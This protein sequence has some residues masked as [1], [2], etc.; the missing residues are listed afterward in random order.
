MRQLP[1]LCVALAFIIF[2]TIS[3][4]TAFGDPPF[5]VNS[6]IA[7]RYAVAGRLGEAAT[8]VSGLGQVW[9]R[10]EFRFDVIHPSPDR[11]DWGLT[12]EM[13]G[14]LA[15]RGVRIL[16][17]LDYSVGWATP[18]WTGP[19]WALVRSMP[20][21]DAW[22]SFVRAV[23]SRYKGRVSA[24]E[25]WNEENHDIF[26][27]PQPDVASYVRLLKAS[28]A[29]I[30]AVDPT[31]LVVLGGTSGVDVAF[32]ESVA[33][34]GGWESFDVLAV[35]TYVGAKSPEAGRLASSELA[36]AQALLNRLGRKPV[37]ITEMGWP[38]SSG[39]W[40]VKS[41][42]TQASYL[43]RGM[44]AA[45]SSGAEKVFWY[46]LAN[47]GWDT[48]SDEA[49]YGLLRKDWR[50]P[51][52]GYQAYRTL[53]AVLSGAL[54]QG[55]LDVQTGSRVYLPLTE[56]PVAWHVWGDGAGGAASFAS[57]V[58]LSGAGSLRIDYWFDAP[59]KDYVD[60]SA[61]T[62]VP[63]QPNKVGLW[64]WGD[65]G[66]HLLWVTFTDATG[67]RFMVGLGNVDGPG[68]HLRTARLADYFVSSGGNGD[69]K[70]DYPVTFQ[71]LMVDNDPDGKVGRGTLYVDDLFFEEGPDIQAFRFSRD[72]QAVDVVWSTDG[73]ATVTLP[74]SS[75]S[76]TVTDRDGNLSS[77]AVHDG[78]L[79]IDVSD[80][81]KYVLHRPAQLPSHTGASVSSSFTLTPVK[82]G[83]RYFSETG[84]NVANGFLYYWQQNGGLER[85]GYPI[86]E[87]F[88]EDGLTVQYFERAK[89]E[90]HPE[91]RGTPY[92]VQLTLLGR[93]LTS[94]RVFEPV[95][96]FSSTFDRWYFP[97]TGHSLAYGFLRY[98]LQNGGLP[99]F[100]YPISEEF[101]ERNSEDGKV[102]T[103]Q[104]FERQRFEYHPEHRGTRFEVLLGLLGK[105]MA[106]ARGYLP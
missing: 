91:L 14:R 1:K 30:K 9:A 52:K 81:P 88:V 70:I 61:P 67:E 64:L 71:S 82:P 17:L 41:E 11:W 55:R 12:D 62:A 102:Y 35:H 27:H 54:P 47:D 69:G 3:P 26:W 4:A 32:L 7:T 79:R 77:V 20:D 97:E 86:S 42:D 25:I 23:V 5:G 6:H 40:G 106:R 51:K 29:E 94:G 68:W 31:A 92:E 65:N 72:S 75:A 87:E 44:V 60:I 28:F 19:S 33:A 74:S 34:G 95:P 43:V 48:S 57:E 18:G 39:P 10:E 8:L 90:Y 66:G 98:W 21:L 73:P 89:F 78:M 16:G 96:A 104:Y 100:G 53:V 36:K 58:A 63:G 56:Q 50:S 46:D 101:D 93:S 85:F 2:F 83:A 13:V 45:I 80:A 22:R 76:A 105:E 38:S 24:W 15:E 84:H 59:G 99:I 103:V 49:N 37:W